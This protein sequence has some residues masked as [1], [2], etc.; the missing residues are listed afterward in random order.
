MKELIA[1]ERIYVDELLSVL[2]VRIFCYTPSVHVVKPQLP[3]IRSGIWINVSLFSLSTLQGYRAEMEDPAM[4]D[5]LPSAL[6][7]QKDLLFGNMPEIYQFHSRQSAPKHTHTHT[8]QAV[9]PLDA[10]SNSFLEFSVQGL[11]PRPSGLPGDAW[12]GGVLLPATGEDNRLMLICWD[13]HPEK[14]ETIY[15]VGQDSGSQHIVD[16]YEYLYFKCILVEWWIQS[17][18]HLCEQK[19]KFEVYERYCQ[20]KPRSELLW[21]RC[22]DSP[23]FQVFYKLIILHN[24]LT[25][26][27][28]LVAV[29]PLF[30]CSRSARR[31]WTTSWVWTLICWSRSNASPS[32]NCFSR[33]FI[34][35]RWT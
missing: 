13:E 22:C 24:P 25:G 26:D 31:S 11:P 8:P 27:L 3:I 32:T 15:T 34:A 16:L 9:C 21:R 18:V 35:N 19:E 6:H 29:A 7:S 10:S 28:C 2:L 23:F 20:N 30:F 5:L 17:N 1:T 33:Y 4:S 14:L 12:D